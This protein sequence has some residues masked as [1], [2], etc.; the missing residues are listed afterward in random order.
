MSKKQD[1]HDSQISALEQQITS[2]KQTHD[3]LMLIPVRLEQEKTTTAALREEIAELIRSR[4]A[5]A[6]DG[7]GATALVAEL[8]QQLGALENMHSTMT[9]A[10]A[11]TDRE[12]RQLQGGQC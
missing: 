7:K 6:N 4:D 3:E 1:A 9:D 5:A 2:A 11:N 8:R 12:K 10:L